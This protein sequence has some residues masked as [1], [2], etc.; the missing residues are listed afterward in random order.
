[1]PLTYHPAVFHVNDIAQAMAVIMTPEG[2]TTAERWE[3]ETPISP[4]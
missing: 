2:S 1:M 3:T 4:I